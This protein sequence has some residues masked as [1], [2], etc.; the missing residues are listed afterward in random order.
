VEEKEVRWGNVND[1]KCALARF[2]LKRSI[3]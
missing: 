2:A 1:A 3:Q